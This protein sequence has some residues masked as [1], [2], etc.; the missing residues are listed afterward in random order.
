MNRKIQFDTPVA[1]LIFNRPDNTRKVF[2]AIRERK[3]ATLLV[4]ADGPRP[5]KPEEKER[6]RQTRAIIDQGVDWDCKVLKAY[7]EVNLG[8][9][10]RI[11]SGL[12]WVFG[13]V[14][15]AIIL[16]DDCLPDPSF[17]PYC[18]AMLERYRNDSRIFSIA[19][20]NFVPE[21]TSPTYSYH[22]SRFAN[23]WG[24]ASWRRV[25]QGFYDVEMASWPTT[26]EAFLRSIDGDVRY[27]LYWEYI[28]DRT[29]TGKIDTWDYQFFYACMAQHGLNAIP[30]VNLVTNI[31]F[32][33]DATHTTTVNR[34]AEMPRSHL[35]PDLRHPPFALPDR[36]ADRRLQAASFHL[37]FKGFVKHGGM[38][39]LDSIFKG[40]S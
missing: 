25:W 6:C 19:G 18:R 2:E 11:S 39:L 35:D 28:L 33:G 22:F 31:G 40:K 16:E 21:E 23:I 29:F 7:S 36:D 1:F 10:N 13:E 38:K 37:G 14:E 4:V 12:N 32:Q 17:F 24:W 9:R 8:C 27:R 3:P 15:E 5:G 20:T 26:K 34:F 30:S